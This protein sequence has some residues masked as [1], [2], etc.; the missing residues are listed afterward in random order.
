MSTSALIRYGIFFVTG[1][2]IPTISIFF[3][4]QNIF[5][6]LIQEEKQ[7]KVVFLIHFRYV[8]ELNNMLFFMCNFVAKNVFVG[9]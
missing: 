2:F 6:K 7:W 5:W 3:S 1:N 8:I 4:Q 9:K